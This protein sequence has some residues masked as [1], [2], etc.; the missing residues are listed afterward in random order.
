MQ[1]STRLTSNLPLLPCAEACNDYT[2]VLE[3]D[4]Q[5]AHAKYNRALALEKLGLTDM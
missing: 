3:G 5:N 2:C 1:R 4:P